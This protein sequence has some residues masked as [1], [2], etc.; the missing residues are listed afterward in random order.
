[1]YSDGEYHDALYSD[2]LICYRKSDIQAK[3]LELFTPSIPASS[4]KARK[5]SSKISLLFLDKILESLM[6]SRKN[7][8]MDKLVVMG[9]SNGNSRIT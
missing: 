4:D 5:F 7:F 1:M 6:K 8:G 2:A 9:G 3:L